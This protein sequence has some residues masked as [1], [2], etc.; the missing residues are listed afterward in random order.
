MASKLTYFWM[1]NF[2]DRKTSWRSKTSEKFR[3]FPTFYG[4]KI[5]INV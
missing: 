4:T 2:L 1:L 3:I 5:F